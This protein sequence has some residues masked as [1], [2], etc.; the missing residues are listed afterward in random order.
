MPKVPGVECPA[1]PA[2]CQQYP[3]LLCIV[4]WGSLAPNCVSALPTLFDVASSLHSAME[5]LFCQFQDI[6]WVFYTDVI[7]I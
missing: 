5:N 1:H 3:Y 4:L 7:V 2:P 6:F